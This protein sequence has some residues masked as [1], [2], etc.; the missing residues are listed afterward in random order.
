MCA[1]KPE[2]SNILPCPALLGIQNSG[3]EE[4]DHEMGLTQPA[5]TQ[6]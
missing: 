1:K 2:E 3:P 6:N 4:P 5:L